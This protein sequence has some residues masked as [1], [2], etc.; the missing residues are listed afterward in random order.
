MALTGTE[1]DSKLKQWL[2]WDKNEESRNELLQLVENKHVEELRLRLLSC[3]EFGTAGLRAR[4]GAGFSMMNDLT[5]IQASQGLCKYV[6]S[7][8]SQKPIVIGYDGRHHSNRFALLT[9]GI[10]VNQ[11]IPVY[12]FSK[13]CPTPYVPY[14]VLHL[15]CICGVMITASHNPKD[16]NGYKVYWTNGAQITSPVDKEISKC[17]SENLEPWKTSWDTSVLKTSPQC[18][19]PYDKIFE[20]YNKDVVQL[21]YFR[22]Q[23][24]ASSVKFTYTAMHGVGYLYAVKSLQMFGFPPP[25][26]VKEQVEPNPEFPTVK[27]PNPEEG[28][29][30]LILAMKTADEHD[31][32]VILANDPDAD[33]LALAEKSPSGEWKI[34]TG[35]EMGALL[36]WWS[37]YTFHQKNPNVPASDVYMLASTVS[38]KILHTIAQKEGFN[39]EETLTGFKWMGNKADQLKHQQKTV[40]FAFEEAIGFMCGTAVLDKDGISAAAV[41]AEMTTYV[42]AQ[43]KTL[44]Q[45]L[46]D[47]YTQYGFHLCSNSYFICYQQEIIQQMFNELRNYNETNK[48]PETCGPY[49]IKYVRDLTEGYDN[50]QPDNKPVLPVSRSSQMI[51]FTFENG[52]TATIRTSGTEP[53]IKYYTEHRPDPKRGMDQAEAQNEL[54]NIVECIKTNF[55]RPDKFGLIVRT[56][57]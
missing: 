18:M 7:T 48:Y 35:N 4:M 47:I 44:A 17:I 41:C 20:A 24:A 19:D 21:C 39:F 34:F 57:S 30:A 15:G 6:L 26:P 23:N 2:D 54:D 13:M 10:F 50:S 11:G 33:R 3:M 14:T 22:E 56:D 27:Y 9:A 49:K 8:G 31:S 28:K 40:I 46:E 16:D 52:C 29:G 45:K 36:G 42:Y 51:T 37:W 5:I 12:L 1:V 43:G 25:I 32:P 38:S 53:K 55:F